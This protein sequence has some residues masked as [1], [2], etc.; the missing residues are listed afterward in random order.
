MPPLTSHTRSRLF[1]LVPALALLAACLLFGGEARAQGI[2]A[3]RKQGLNADGT[4]TLEGIV[5]SPT[6]QLPELN[7]RVRLVSAEGIVRIAIPNDKGVVIFPNLGSGYYTLY[8]EAGKDYERSEASVYI[9]A[10]KQHATLSLFLRFRPEANPALRGVPQPAADLFV[11]AV[12]VSRK[13]DDRKAAELLREAIAKDP[14]FALAHNELG[15]ILMRG[16][17]LDEALEEFRAAQK[18]LPTDAEVA[19]N[20]GSA[21]ALKKEFAEAAKQL[22]FGLKR[23]DRSATGHLYLGVALIGLKNIDEAE[24]EFQQA[25]R[26]GGDQMGAAHKYLGG[27]YWR[28]GDYKK[29]ADELETYLRLTPKAPDAEKV[30][31]TIKDLRGKS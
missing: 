10:A 28:R 17:R 7:M 12:E 30:R 11:K 13:G 29:A 24:R 21:L 18:A 22:Q 14:L 19:I 23:L 16:G 2:G 27:I 5:V 31:G 6:G 20:Y 3:H 26:L 9:D 8:L 1:A 25:A 4:S 15:L